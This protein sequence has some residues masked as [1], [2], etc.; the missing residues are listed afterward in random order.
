MNNRDK[1]IK[2]PE[3]WFQRA[4]AQILATAG[5][6]QVFVGQEVIKQKLPASRIELLFIKG[7]GA[8]IDVNDLGD[9]YEDD[10]AG[11]LIFT[12]VT[13]REESQVSLLEGVKTLHEDWAATV[14]AAMDFKE[15]PFHGLL[16][17]YTVNQIGEGQNDRD[18]DLN[19]W[20]DYTRIPFDLRYTIN[21]DAWTRA[22][23][24]AG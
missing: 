8:E 22:L 3:G 4:G 15:D 17:F 19:F 18:L 21:Q 1:Q 13:R 6:G 5:R 14:R 2:N 11:R 7:P 12:L 23:P 20:L 16:P 24:A 10:I 9:Q